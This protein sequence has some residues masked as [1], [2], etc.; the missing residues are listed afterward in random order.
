MFYLKSHLHIKYPRWLHI[1][2]WPPLSQ[3]SSSSNSEALL[4]L[5]T[6]LTGLVRLF[7]PPA[8]DLLASCDTKGETNPD[9]LLALS[10]STDLRSLSQPGS[11]EVLTL[12]YLIPNLRQF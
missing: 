9:I 12:T 6:P 8:R 5:A 3:S 10:V 2:Q 4:T 7:S 1:T 11:G